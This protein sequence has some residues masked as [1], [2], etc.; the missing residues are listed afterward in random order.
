MKAECTIMSPFVTHQVFSWNPKVPWPT[1][2]STSPTPEGL[3]LAPQL[4]WRASGWYPWHWCV[5]ADP[6]LL[7]S[8]AVGLVTAF[9]SHPCP[10][11]G[12]ALLGGDLSPHLPS[13]KHILCNCPSINSSSHPR[14]P[15][16]LLLC[17][18]ELLSCQLHFSISMATT[19]PTPSPPIS[20]LIPSSL[21]K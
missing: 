2:G 14:H 1:Y 21:C 4:A 19:T 5:S 6:V 17:S 13:S 7:A 8:L 20:L 12:S 10:L 15:P 9:C 18:A 16:L 3:W 11:A